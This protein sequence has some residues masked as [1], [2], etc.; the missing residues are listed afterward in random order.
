M[1]FVNNWLR[2]IVLE[3]GAMECPLDLPDGTYRLIVA[4]RISGASRWEIVD[5]TVGDGMAELLRG[6][7]GTEE[8]DWESG[9]VIYLSLTAGQLTA[10]YTQLAD[11]SEQI[12]SLSARLAALEQSVVPA[13]ALIDADGNHLVDDQGNYLTMEYDKNG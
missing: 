9:S 11:Q 1:K 8:Q 6:L 3:R 13:G 4:D 10:L 7:E 5:A 12:V 2:G